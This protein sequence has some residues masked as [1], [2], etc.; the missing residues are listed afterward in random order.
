MIV[1]LV[2]VGAVVGFGHG[3]W[4][5]LDH[6]NSTN[7]YKLFVIFRAFVGMIAGAFCFLI[8]WWRFVF[9]GCKFQAL[10]SI[11]RICRT[12]G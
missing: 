10:R 2:G 3:G 12:H 6:C 11:I 7:I 8:H 4:I 9:E 5:M 1:R